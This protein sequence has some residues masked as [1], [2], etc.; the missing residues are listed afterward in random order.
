VIP[1]LPLLDIWSG[2]AF[3]WLHWMQ[4]H[5]RGISR[6]IALVPLAPIVTDGVRKYRALL[7]ELRGCDTTADSWVPFE[8]VFS[9]LIPEV[10]STVAASG[11]ERPVLGMEG[12]VVDGV[13]VG[14][15]ALRLVSVTLEREVQAGVWLAPHRAE[16]STPVGGVTYLESLSSTYW[17]AHRPSILPIAKPCESVKQLTTLVCH[18]RGLCSVL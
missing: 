5:L 17:I 13:D 8:T 15:V 3:V 16:Q 4:H 18:L 11:A 2:F 7:V 9:I 10:E 6:A 12:D 14:Y 1:G